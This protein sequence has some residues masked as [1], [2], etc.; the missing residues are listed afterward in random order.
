MHGMNILQHI[1][2][3]EL[4][5]KE[6]VGTLDP[7]DKLYIINKAR[8]NNQS[9]D[10]A[11]QEETDMYNARMRESNLDFENKR[12]IIDRIATPD[13][14][15]LE[16]AGFWESVVRLGPQIGVQAGLALTTGP[17]WSAAF[18]GNQIFGSTYENARAK[19]ASHE[20]SVGA[21][22]MNTALQTPMEYI[23]IGKFTKF[24]K[25]RGP[26]AQ[27]FK[28]LIQTMG[29]EWFTEFAQAY[30]EQ[31]A[32]VYA[33]NPDL[34]MLEATWESVNTAEKLMATAKQGAEE[35]LIVL[36]WTLLGASPRM[37]SSARY[38]KES[39]A[40][41]LKDFATKEEVTD[42]TTPE[43]TDEEGEGTEEA[44][45]QE[46]PEAPEAPDETP[47]KKDVDIP[48]KKTKMPGIEHAMPSLPDVKEK[49]AKKADEAAAELGLNIE[50]KEKEP[51]I[52]AE[53]AALDREGIRKG[54]RGY[55]KRVKNYKE[56][57]VPTIRLETPDGPKFMKG[58][59]TNWT[60]ADRT[61]NFTK[62]R[63]QYRS[64]ISRLRK[65]GQPIDELEYGFYH[66]EHGFIDIEAPIFFREGDKRWRTVAQDVQR[67]IA[68]KDIKGKKER[69]KEARKFGTKNFNVMLAEGFDEEGRKVAREEA[70]AKGKRR[71]LSAARAKAIHGRIS[72]L[73]GK[74]QKEYHTG[75]IAKALRAAGHNPK[76]DDVRTQSLKGAAAEAIWEW[77]LNNPDKV[78]SK[79]AAIGKG[80]DAILKAVGEEKFDVGG[81][82]VTSKVR[83]ESIH[84]ES[85]E[86]YEERLTAEGEVGMSE[87]EI[88]IRDRTEIL[89][90][91][92]QKALG[93]VKSPKAKKKI[94]NK[95]T[96]LT[97]PSFRQVSAEEHAKDIEVI[98]KD[99]R[100]NKEK[101]P[102]EFAA[103]SNQINQLSKKEK[104]VAKGHMEPTEH[105][106]PTEYVPVDGHGPFGSAISAATEKYDQEIKALQNEKGITEAKAEEAHEIGERPDLKAFEINRMGGKW[107]VVEKHKVLEQEPQKVSFLS[108]KE[109]GELGGL[110]KE[111]LQTAIARQKLQAGKLKEEIKPEFITPGTKGGPVTG[112]KEGQQVRSAE[113]GVIQTGVGLAPE[114]VTGKRVT[115]AKLSSEVQKHYRE[116]APPDSMEGVQKEQMRQINQAKKDRKKVK[117]AKDILNNPKGN[118]PLIND[119]AS[120]AAEKIAGIPRGVWNTI[121]AIRFAADIESRFK[122]WA[123]NSGMV[124]KNHFGIR[125]AHQIRANV[126]ATKITRA[127]EKIIGGKMTNRKWFDAVMVAENP[128]WKV[129]E[130]AVKE[131]YE[132]AGKILR[133]HFE[134][135]RAILK[136]R[137]YDP[138]NPTERL[139]KKAY[140]ALEEAE[141]YTEDW[142]K[143]AEKISMYMDMNY[144]HIPTS[145]L[146][147]P[148]ASKKHKKGFVKEREGI[149]NLFNLLTMQ[150]R[151]SS[152]T[153]LFNRAA[154]KEAKEKGE[155]S[156]AQQSMIDL[157]SPAA[158]VMNYGNRFAKDMAKLDL[159]DTLIVDEAAIKMG[160]KDEEG[161]EI[162]PKSGWVKYNSQKAGVF[163]GYAVDA[164]ADEAMTALFALEGKRKWYDKVI[165]MTKM[166]AFYNPFFLPIY[167]VYQSFMTGV[168]FRKN[169]GMTIW[170]LG[171]AIKHTWTQS[172]VYLE[173][174]ELGLFSKP[175]D[176]PFNQI[177]QDM[178]NITAGSNPAMS[179][180]KTLGAAG[181]NSLGLM[182]VY[183][184][185]WDTAWKLDETVRM[186]TYLQLSNGGKKNKAA[187]AQTAARFHGDYASV[188]PK[189]RKYLNRIFF[190]PTF[191]LAMGKLYLNMLNSIW[192]APL[193]VIKGQKTTEQQQQL[194]YLSGLISTAG[195]TYGFDAFMESLGYSADDDEGWWGWNFGRKYVRRAFTKW[196]PKEVTFTWSNPGNLI[197][198]YS[199]RIARAALKIKRRDNPVLSTL[200]ILKWDLHPIY[201]TLWGALQNRKPDGSKIWRASESLP[202]IAVNH[203]IHFLE[204][205]VRIS[206]LGLAHIPDS[207]ST[208]NGAL[209]KREINKLHTGLSIFVDNFANM[210]IAHMTVRDPKRLRLKR[211]LDRMKREFKSDQRE[212]VLQHGYYNKKWLDNATDLLKGVQKEIR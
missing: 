152:L 69:K 193:A 155:L 54:P 164:R 73:I 123:E 27:K 177:Q 159:L 5:K 205:L 206:E 49:D 41:R 143:A 71:G 191:K 197:Q 158:V 6:F 144:I 163:N 18:M 11:Y 56:L 55:K 162:K 82:A 145:V 194:M 184:V 89:V 185:S 181:K 81:R 80:K 21:G 46:E 3:G 31:V 187:A 72:K 103:V 59:E 169:P 32:N 92:L 133:S 210:T 156:A 190:T 147:A 45:E 127:I 211:D 167:D 115:I 100:K 140:E 134:A 14:K 195:L 126:E 43:E 67:K 202:T 39:D 171:S 77:S 2:Q 68:R 42:E 93:K 209:V 44:E 128:D 157:L 65:A 116:N 94:H 160:E 180:L 12:K 33:E 61:N 25:T 113:E 203:G 153:E 83:Q 53:Q 208:R 60:P 106:V 102:D 198:R 129:A 28:D 118:S 104:E 1:N 36:P 91:V 66:K 176:F 98:K 186:W 199:Q 101:V 17:A 29:T 165:N 212:H 119:L 97:D 121:T 149:D 175:F 50:A 174:M 161:N 10:E 76:A 19:G 204:G 22:L 64:I 138:G 207:L 24:V 37:V 183:K 137:G 135:K 146:W 7:Q 86:G 141:P 192:K 114:Q 87:Q 196:G 35:G 38:K 70:I 178:K 112:S 201:Q 172:D 173:A 78:L 150:E 13:A 154:T 132:K 95:I 139:L 188:P 117:G 200:E 170:N 96:K 20:R 30:P 75:V 125:A 107:Y 26:L 52:T 108:Q 15:Y 130:G 142:A 9:V 110:T 79:N 168:H 182:S 23:G 99:I 8:L 166:F 85:E 109:E 151:T 111:E 131:D 124:T 122:G 40:R 84:K 34:N 120:W 74:T 16:G 148:V 88:E 62:V 58:E 179:Y 90:S 105:R 57:N 189:T 136:E 48:I 4:T 47:P 51:T 63:A